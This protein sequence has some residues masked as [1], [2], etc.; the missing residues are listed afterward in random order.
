[1]SDFNTSKKNYK[2]GR[3]KVEGR[4]FQIEFWDEEPFNLPYVKV[5][6][7]VIEP[8]KPHW[9]SHKTIMSEAKRY[10][11]HGW[12]VD[13]RLDWAMAIITHYLQK[14]R[15]TIEESRQIEAFCSTKQ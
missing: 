12:T 11:E 15:D 2:V 10:I 8:V 9:F 5:S 4:T 1:M 3:T 14:E 7:I 6:E 13:N